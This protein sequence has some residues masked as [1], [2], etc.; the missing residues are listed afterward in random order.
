MWRRPSGRAFIA[1]HVIHDEGEL[2][3]EG[4]LGL[5]QTAALCDTQAPSLDGCPLAGSH[6]HH[7]SGG[8]QCRLRE[9][10]ARSADMAPRVGLDGLVLPGRK[11]KMSPDIA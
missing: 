8:E 11:A 6:Q 2:A 7:M 5:L 1:P 10:I 4:N 3:G 9:H